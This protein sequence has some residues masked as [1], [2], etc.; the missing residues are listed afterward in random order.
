[1]RLRRPGRLSVM[2][3]RGPRRSLSTHGSRSVI[4][5]NLVHRC[6][7]GVG[8]FAGPLA[9]PTPSALP[10]PRQQIHGSREGSCKVRQ[11]LDRE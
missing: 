3:T 4:V 7:S 1:M 2:N 5:R 9:P 11:A 10:H 8:P 6:L